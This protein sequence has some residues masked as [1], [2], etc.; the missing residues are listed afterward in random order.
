MKRA[1]ILGFVAAI[2]ATLAV[3]VVSG[4]PGSVT[5]AQS[6]N[7]SAHLSGAICDGC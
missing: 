6:E 4:Q 2:A 5:P 1:K 7:V 3:I